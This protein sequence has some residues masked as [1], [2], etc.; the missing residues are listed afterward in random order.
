[1]NEKGQSLVKRLHTGAI[2]LVFILPFFSCSRQK[3]EGPEYVLKSGE[4][5]LSLDGAWR[6][7]SGDLAP[8]PSSQEDSSWVIV[9]MPDLWSERGIPRAG[10]GWYQSRILIADSIHPGGLGLF[11]E[12]V[13]AAVEIYWDGTLIGRNGI[14]ADNPS[15]EAPTNKTYLCQIPSELATTGAHRLAMRVSN[16]HAWTGGVGQTPMIGRHDSL[17][18]FRSLHQYLFGFLFGIFFISGLYHLILYLGGRERREYLIFALLSFGFVLF[19]LLELSANLGDLDA[20]LYNL[21]IKIG[22]IDTLLLVLL[23]YYF[24]V[25]QFDYPHRWLMRTVVAIT[26]LLVPPVFYREQIIDLGIEWLLRNWWIQI[27]AVGIVYLC[28]WA[29]RKRRPGSII[30]AIGALMLA[31]GGFMSV[32]HDSNMIAYGAFSAFVFTMSVTLSQKMRT[33]ENEI[34]RMMQMFRLFVPDQVLDRIAK[35]G[36]DSIKLGSAEEGTASILFSDIRSFSTIA[37]ELTPGDTLGYLNA[38]M[39]RM[40]PVIQRHNGFVNQFVGDAIMAIFY[41]STHSYDAVNSALDMRRTLNEFNIEREK[42]GEKPIEIGIGINT[43]RVIVGT[44]GS[45][46]RMESAV[47]GDAVNLGSRIEQLTKRYRVG[48]LITDNN[49]LELPDRE[50]YCSREVDIVQVKGKNK[51][52]TLYEIYDADSDALKKL[53]MDSMADFYQG[54]LYYR[55]MEWEKAMTAFSRAL[56]IYPRDPVAELYVERCIL[57]QRQPPPQEWNGVTVLDGK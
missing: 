20:S 54:V 47:I 15:D 5:V 13:N 28:W 21:Q 30:L 8:D 37:E 29:I 39:Q 49:Y 36:I 53:K 14:V 34:K 19:V 50:R 12:R 3:Q 46:T 48:I 1:M 23:S 52:V 45:E 18:T 25:I 6:F 9:S 27:A 10:L 57:L 4:R 55:A 42:R 35:A 7:R 31:F 2:F 43:G 44:I 51:V 41:T 33:L 56:K 22:W 40:T 11:F 32:Y 26:L 24:L 17:I 38:F 16:H